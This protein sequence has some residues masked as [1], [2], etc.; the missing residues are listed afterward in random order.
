MQ[1]KE[2]VGSSVCN[3]GIPNPGIP[4]VFA[5]AESRDW[6]HPNPRI[7]VFQKKLFKIVF[8]GLNDTNNK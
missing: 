6:W 8:S 1:S 7:L 5:N 2:N 3:P 4:A